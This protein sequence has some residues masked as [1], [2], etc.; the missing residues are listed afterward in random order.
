MK[1]NGS[2]LSKGLLALVVG[3][4]LI[5][6]G[7]QRQVVHQ[8]V[9]E[10][11]QARALGTRVLAAYMP[12]FGD[13]QH[14][15]VGYSSQ[16]PKVLRK[17]IDQ[18][19]NRGITGFVVDWNGARRPFTDKSFAIL[20]QV[21]GEA[22]FQVALLYNEAEEDTAEST[23]QALD[24]M[25]EAYRDY[26]G[27]QAPDRA[28]Y[29]G[30]NGR[31][32]IFIFPKRGQTDWNRV[33]E[34]VN[35]WSTPPLLFYKDQAPEQFAGAFDGYYA[36]VHPGPGGWKPDGKDWGEQYLDHFY[37][38]VKDK[39]PDK[40]AVGG[41]WPGFDD[42]RARWGLNRKMDRRCGAT[43][44]DTLRLYTRYYDATHPLPFLMIDTWNDY[45]EGTAIERL[46]TPCTGQKP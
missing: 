14:L 16:D 3:A 42:H 40:I 24:A 31:P 10:D 17:Q 8:A 36:W 28:A 32:M 21:A 2:H 35:T 13:G 26:I 7:C 29:L 15:D 33:R 46:D 44:D 11:F 30:Y 9:Q 39:Y 45:E 12:W 4:V 1:L 20:Q 34:H 37:K 43:L 22:H 18:A 6:N 27:P 38:N 5:V 25:D 41:A 19:R 23:Q